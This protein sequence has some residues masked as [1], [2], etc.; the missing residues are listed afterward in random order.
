MGSRTC[1]LV[2]V[3]AASLGASVTVAAQ[4]TFDRRFEAPPG[5]H[6]TLH[7][8]VGSVAIVGG[9]A[10]EVLVHVDMGESDHLCVEAE[11][12]ASG[13]SVTGH[14]SQPS[15]TRGWGNSAS[16]VRFK[17]VVPRDY[18]VELQTSGGSLDL[19]HLSA[20]VAGQTS[21]GSVKLEDILG[22]IEAH[23]SGGSVDAEKI[24]GP[25]RLGTAGGSITIADASGDLDLRTLGGSINLRSDDG[26]VTA[27]TSGGSVRAEVRV[28]RGIALTS[29]GGPITLLIP[30]NVRASIDAQTSGGSVQSD[31]PVI[32]TEAEQHSRIR[33]ALNGGGEPII[34]DSSGGSIHIEQLR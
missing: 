31:L 14:R 24:H 34:L 25:T 6:L 27:A 8:D 16:H 20:S 2:V 18:P 10:H 30:E 7:T 23:T 3:A 4:Q 26:K 22:P 1:G 17:I 5:G 21:G 9:D 19:S 33:G 12:N 29:S 13:L 28:N 15:W 32:R 11:Q